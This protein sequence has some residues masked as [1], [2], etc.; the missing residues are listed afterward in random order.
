MPI[1]SSQVILGN[2]GN[3]IKSAVGG[4]GINLAQH[5]E[6]HSWDKP[7]PTVAY[8]LLLMTEELQLFPRMLTPMLTEANTMMPLLI[9][10]TYS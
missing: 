7:A 4:M 5:C 2:V 8:P 10:S 6:D 9:M 1:K 3:M